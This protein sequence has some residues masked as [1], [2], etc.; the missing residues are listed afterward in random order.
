M[1]Y[2]EFYICNVD[3]MAGD[4]TQECLEQTILKDPYGNTKFHIIVPQSVSPVMNTTLVLP[5]NLV[6]SHCVFQVK[7]FKLKSISHI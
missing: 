5:S 7:I 1:G 6:C 3:G 2:F 4:A